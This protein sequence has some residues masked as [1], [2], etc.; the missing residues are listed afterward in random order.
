M[1]NVGVG[2][3]RDDCV[4]NRARCKRSQPA[5]VQWR[6]RLKHQNN[7]SKHVQNDIEY[8]QGDCVLRP[9][10][11]S[12]VDA[13]LTP[14]QWAGRMVASVHDPRQV[15]TQWIGNRDADNEN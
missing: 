15:F 9:V 12:A 7:I 4:E 6:K 8:E 1:L 2:A 5:W 13:V 3:E 10:L 11:R 14:L